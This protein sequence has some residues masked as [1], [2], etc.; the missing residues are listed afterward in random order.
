MNIKTSQE[1]LRLRNSLQAISNISYS[2]SKLN[3][4]FPIDTLGD[5]DGK[6][7]INAYKSLL[8]DA[9]TVVGSVVENNC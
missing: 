6:Q 7:I 8:L 5:E 4:K 9:K 2:F 1:I 3:Q